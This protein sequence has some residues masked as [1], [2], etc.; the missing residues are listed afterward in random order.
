MGCIALVGI[1]IVGM[2]SFISSREDF[3]TNPVWIKC[4]ELGNL[5]K[6]ISTNAILYYD[7]NG[8]EA[9]ESPVTCRIEITTYDTYTHQSIGEPE[10]KQFS[11]LA[12]LTEFVANAKK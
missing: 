9:S 4:T 3:T 2:F 5:K 7:I 1:V 11:D 8:T 6:P 10:K 12:E